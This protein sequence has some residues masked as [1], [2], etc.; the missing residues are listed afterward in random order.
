MAA[1]SFGY[2]MYDTI[3]EWYFG[4]FDLGMIAHHIASMAAIVF[5]LFEQYGGC[6]MMTGLYYAEMSGPCFIFRC[7][8]K[9]QNLESTRKYL[10][11]VTLYSI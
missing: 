5:I 2:F 7:A 10:Y 11:V 3:A 9:R 8:F 1:N 4:T 6:A